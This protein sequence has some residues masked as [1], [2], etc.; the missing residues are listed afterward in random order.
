[1]NIFLDVLIHVCSY[2][3][4]F[5]SKQIIVTNGFMDAKWSLL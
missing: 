5:F 2:F 3:C 4:W 1:M